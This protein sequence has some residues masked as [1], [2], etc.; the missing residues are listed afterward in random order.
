[1]VPE[2]NQRWQLLSRIY[3]AALAR[4]PSERAA[5]LDDA[6]AGD[7]NLREEVQSMLDHADAGGLLDDSALAHRGRRAQDPLIDALIGRAPISRRS[8]R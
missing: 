8:M 6:C 4:T 7:T 3:D 5:F 2:A 1:M